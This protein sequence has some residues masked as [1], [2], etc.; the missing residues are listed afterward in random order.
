M[1][2]RVGRMDLFFGMFFKTFLSVSECVSYTITKVQQFYAVSHIFFCVRMP[3]LRSPNFDCPDLFGSMQHVFVSHKRSF[4]GVCAY[5]PS[6]C[7][8]FKARYVFLWWKV[9]L[10]WLLWLLKLDHSSRSQVVIPQEYCPYLTYAVARHISMLKVTSRF[11]IQSQILAHLPIPNSQHPPVWSKLSWYV[12]ARAMGIHRW[13]C[14][15]PVCHSAN[16][17]TQ[18]A[19]WT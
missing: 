19:V 12:I 9:V 13:A 7:L 5:S 17:G 18:A 11:Q 4:C 3:F 6:N 14:G 15:P 1:V 10:F 16:R 8:L 2:A